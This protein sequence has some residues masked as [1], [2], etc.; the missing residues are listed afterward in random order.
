MLPVVLGLLW[1][2]SIEHDPDYATSFAFALFMTAE[3]EER[4][5]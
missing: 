4:D 2:L 1:E 5:Q 3:T